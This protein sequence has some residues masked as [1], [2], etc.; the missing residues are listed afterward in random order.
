MSYSQEEEKTYAFVC[1]ARMKEESGREREKH[2][3]VIRVWDEVVSR[4]SL[5]DSNMQIENASI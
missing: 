4:E 3:H 5:N 1:A 2:E